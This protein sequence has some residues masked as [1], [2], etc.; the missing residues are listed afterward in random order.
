MRTTYL[1]SRESDLLTW[2]KNF[3]QKIVADAAAY[4]LI[5]KQATD[6][7][8][9]QAA[10]AAAYQVANDPDTRSPGNIRIKNTK[11]DELVASTRQ[12]VDIAQAAP[13]MDNDKRV[14]LGITVRDTDPTPIPAPS[15]AP[16]IDI[17]S[18]VGWTLELRLHRGDATKR[19]K[20]AG[21]KG[22]TVF[23][24]VGEQP[25]SAIDAWKFEGSITKTETKVNFP[26]TLAPGTKVWL[27]AFW[28]NP[29]SQSGPAAVPVSTQINYGG[30]S[31]AA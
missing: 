2:T 5:E 22:A 18:M 11:K 9:A 31:Q 10:F 24:F 28:F 23:S 20:P 17:L 14:A 21:V 19:A 26:T 3:E 25:P 1:P 13:E 8:L 15:E 4:G 12:L 29:T 16:A 6:Y 27:T 30:L 7:N